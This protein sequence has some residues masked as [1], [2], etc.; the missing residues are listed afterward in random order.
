MRT[1]TTLFLCLVVTA[2]AYAT[3]T[4]DQEQNQKQ[5]Q[6]QEQKQYQGQDQTAMGGNATATQT[7]GNQQQVTFTSPD[8]ITVRNTVSARV[9]NLVATS[10]CFYSWSGG[11]GGAGF[12]IGGGKAKRDPECDKRELARMIAGFGFVDMAMAVA[13]Q[14]EAAINTIGE[15]CAGMVT[16]TQKVEQLNAENERLREQ[17][18]RTK[19]DCKESNNRVFEACQE[20]K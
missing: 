1:F 18:E 14:T 6:D 19:T 4:P 9:P 7:Q 13:C 15:Q 12:N 8:D 20:S 3:N 2:S 16:A 11:V 10:P 5:Y 17:I